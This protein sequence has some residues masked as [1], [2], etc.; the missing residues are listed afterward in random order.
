MQSKPAR[1]L[2]QPDE[3]IHRPKLRQ[4]DA[5][6]HSPKLRQPDQKFH[7]PKKIPRTKSKYLNCSRMFANCQ[8]LFKNIQMFEYDFILSLTHIPSQDTHVMKTTAKKMPRP[9]AGPPPTANRQPAGPAE[10]P[11]PRRPGLIVRSPSRGRPRRRSFNK[12]YE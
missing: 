12:I 6:F 4:P 7:S 1:K 10:L 9:P 11:A 2:R 8:R 5:K 3:K